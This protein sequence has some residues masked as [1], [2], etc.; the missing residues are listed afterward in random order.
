MFGFTKCLAGFNS[1]VDP[2]YPARELHFHSPHTRGWQS[3]RF[4]RFPVEILIKLDAPSHIRQI[5][6]LSHEYKIASRIEM[7]VGLPPPGTADLSKVPM[8]RLGY[9]SF[10]SNERS[11]HQAR[12]LKSVHVDVD[13]LLVRL[14]CHKCHVNKLNIYNQVGIVALNILGTPLDGKPGADPTSSGEDSAHGGSDGLASKLSVDAITA[15]KIQE[16]HRQKEA[17]VA[18]EDYD[19]AKRLKVVIDRLKEVGA[20]VAT[21]E[22]RK[23]QAV[24]NEDYDTAKVLKLEIDRLRNSWSTTGDAGAPI[25]AAAP[26]TRAQSP[27]DIFNRVVASNN[28]EPPVSPRDDVRLPAPRNVPLDDMPV[29]RRAGGGG[30]GFG[31]GGEVDEDG[32]AQPGMESSVPRPA[33]GGGG[34][35]H[36]DR[37]LPTVK[38]GVAPAVMDETSPENDPLDMANRKPRKAAPKPKDAEKEKPRAA[39]PP[40][41]SFGGGAR[42][43]GDDDSPAVKPRP[44][45]AFSDLPPPEPIPP[46]LA[47][48]AAALCEVLPEYTVQCLLSKNWQLRDAA[49]ASISKDLSEGTYPQTPGAI[50]RVV[51]RA[52]NKCMN[53]KVPS[54]FLNAAQLLTDVLGMYAHEVGSRDMH[55]GLTDIVG[56]LLDKSGDPNTRVKDT[57]TNLLVAIARCEEAGLDMLLP[58]IFKPVKNQAQWK[59]VLGRLLLIKRFVDEFGIAPR[60]SLSADTVMTYVKAAFASPN[61]D[62]RNAAT[63]VT[64]QVYRA[65]GTAVDKY[66]KGLKPAQKDVIAQACADADA[67]VGEED[68]APPPA[69]APPP[70]KPAPAAAAAK[71]PAAAAAGGQGKASP[72]PGGAAKG[73]NAPPSRLPSAKK[74]AAEAAKA[75]EPEEDLYEGGG[76][77]GELEEEDGL[78]DVCQFCNVTDPKFLEGENMDLH[79]FHDCPLLCSCDL[80]GQIIEIASVTDH[81][82][83][84]CEVG[85]GSY[86]ACPRCK[87]AVLVDEMPAHTAAKSCLPLKPATENNRCPLC[88]QD[89][90]PGEE[91]WRVHHLKAPG[92]PNNKRSKFREQ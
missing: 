49:V 76:D 88:H 71:K 56:H 82:L 78:T 77:E 55:N 62:V 84:E 72:A 92:C 10:D 65:I 1:A 8:K 38:D 74:P 29:G 30:N 89:I 80:C 51:C 20:K 58:G 22:A 14:V 25:A 4:C 53:D 52:L 81:L 31:L 34:G 54:V 91:G 6:L 28:A 73:G 83:G 5:Q 17:A 23:Q 12:E 13:A 85:Q 43:S 64:V 75:A 67:G 66:T 60:G 18:R 44:S 39:S 46:A 47:G 48:D 61:G 33:L 90:P 11:N 79:F 40:K 50:F 7:Y 45:G 68:V 26:H 57:A 86:T 21:L 9:L 41:R 16:V 35:G 3:P 70:T 15:E 24:E 27:N 42:A 87:E 63:R 19:E 69:A 32:G 36:D 37:P 59:P 2:D